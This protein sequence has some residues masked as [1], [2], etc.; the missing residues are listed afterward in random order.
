[1]CTFIYLYIHNLCRLLLSQMEGASDAPPSRSI[2]DED[3]DPYLLHKML[4]GNPEN[5]EYIAARPF[6]Y[7]PG[8]ENLELSVPGIMLQCVAVCCR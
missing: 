3:E 1:M 8:L 7:I 6:S 5:V 2:D 4:Y